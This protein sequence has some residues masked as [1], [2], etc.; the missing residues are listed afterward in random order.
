MQFNMCYEHT[1]KIN[2]L[3]C[4][5]FMSKLKREL[6]VETNEWISDKWVEHMLG[7]FEE[8]TA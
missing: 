2:N 6:F 5:K 3:E 8:I 4:P 7:C 1:S